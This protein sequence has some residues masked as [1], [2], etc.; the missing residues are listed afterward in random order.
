MF[1]TDRQV[2]N[3]YGVCRYTIWRWV[4][5]GKYPAPK[6]LTSGSTRWHISDIEEFD[7]KVLKPDPE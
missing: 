2:G 6:K 1:M 3:R 4:R 7:R 5:E